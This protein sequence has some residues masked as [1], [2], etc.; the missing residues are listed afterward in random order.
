[1]NE[2]TEK[3]W[4][5]FR[6]E[7]AEQI[8]ALELSLVGSAGDILVNEVFRYM[9]TIKGGCAMMGFSAMESLAHAAEDFLDKVRKGECAL[10]DENVD[11]LLE[12]VDALKLQLQSVEKNRQNPAPQV[13]LVE[14][15]RGL[16]TAAA[17]MRETP[18]APEPAARRKK[19][20]AAAEPVSGVA[21]SAGFAE[22]ACRLLPELA[23]A[24]VG[25]DAPDASVYEPLKV[26]ASAEGLHALVQRLSLLVHAH[27]ENGRQA[28]LADLMDR[29]RY[30]EMETD[31]DCGTAQAA[32]AVYPLVSNRLATVAAELFDS[33]SLLEAARSATSRRAC[34]EA[35]QQFIAS[36]QRVI[37]LAKLLRLEQTLRLLRLASQLLR[38]VMRDMLSFSSELAEV[39]GVVAGLPMELLDSGGEDA[40]YVAMAVQMLE[41]LQ[42]IA[43]TSGRE[44]G[45]QARLGSLKDR[46]GVDYALLESLTP[47]SLDA[48][49]TA[50]RDG[51]TV[52]E[53]EADL[54]SVPDHGEAFVQWMSGA[55]H[56][57]HS[58]TLFHRDAAREERTVLRFLVAFP[59][60]VEDIRRQLG[61]LDPARQW[62]RLLKEDKAAVV[63]ESSAGTAAVT[64]QTSAT[65]RIDSSTLDRFVNR[66]GEMVM[67]R[68]M[69]SH[70][71]HD[72]DLLLRLHRLR[73][74]SS[75]RGVVLS[76]D[77][78][79]ALGALLKDVESRLEELDQ[80][81]GRI[82][83]ALGRL[84]EDVLGLR[85]V[86]IG[87]AFNR[88]PR[89]VRDLSHAQQKLVDLDV[90][91]EDVRIDKGMVDV[92]IEPLMHMVRNSVDHGIETP[93]EREQAG[94]P[95]RARLQLRAR[96]QGNSLIIEIADDGRGLNRDRIRRKAFAAGLVPDAD[97]SGFTDRELCNLIFLPGFST[98]EQVTEVSGRGVGMDIV[99][100]RVAQVGGQIEV[101]STPGAGVC[102]TLRLPLSAAI[103]S[104][105]M[106]ASAGRQYAL[107]ERNVMEV[108]SIPC[109]A[110]QRIQGQI[111][112]LLRGVPLPLYHLGVLLGGREPASAPDEGK[113]EV[114]VLSDGVY[115]IGI[116]V[117]RVLGRPEVFVRDM[118][119][120][121]ARLPGVGGVSILG[122]GGVLIILDCERLFELALRNAQSLRGLLCAT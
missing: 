83:G 47:Q 4:P 63:T 79:D 20:K 93:A 81:D 19:A 57:V 18:A 117:D 122:N 88:L 40:P 102:F 43:R 113:L 14:R 119:P 92:L 29:I 16:A 60:A 3:L 118:H 48:L 28:L 46:I 82:Q 10:N 2:L 34:V 56:I 22:T 96:Q 23:C 110:I 66:V 68:N 65:L 54:E 114:V 75:E 21:S 25:T 52:V 11:V 55:G 72:E 37:V 69:L 15:L 99:K 107:P 91:G 51:R 64:A 84:Q 1:M 30:L 39:F 36:I 73:R 27:D 42:D 35:L 45:R 61:Q 7:V 85:V 105:V 90:S 50:V 80:A 121:I 120:D 98:S 13:A 101:E 32:A 115:R 77:D 78:V 104:V 109:T 6:A 49:E 86:P 71:L 67:L 38:D 116:L 97:A 108:I 95:A 70:T 106:V 53:I 9:H 5:A 76:R 94:K 41:R 59:H 103:Q 100:T 62:Y 87:M 17:A 24:C 58:A 8:E 26:A 31:T 44:V 12:A 112:C 74:L 89:V 111:A 33:L